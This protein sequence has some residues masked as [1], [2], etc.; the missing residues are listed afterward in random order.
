V[1]PECG[2][3]S[4]A[5]ASSF[6]RLMMRLPIGSF[7]SPGEAR[8]IPPGPISLFGTMSVSTSLLYPGVGLSLL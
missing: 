6:G 5:S 2:S 4:F 1:K 3:R 8:R 7:S